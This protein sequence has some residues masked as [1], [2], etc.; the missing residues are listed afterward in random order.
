MKKIFRKDNGEEHNFWMSYTD[1][2]SG[3]LVVFIIA[4]ILY[5][6]ANNKYVEFNDRL[7]SLNITIEQADE[8]LQDYVIKGNMKVINEEFTSVFEIIDSVTILHDQGVIRFYPFQ[9]KEMFE[10]NSDELK[11]N[12]EERLKKVG[13]AFVN[14]AME[15]RKKNAIEIRIEGHADSRRLD[16]PYKDP[17]VNNLLLSSKRAIAVYNCLIERCGLN[18]EEKRFVKENV[19]AV[20]Y[21]S[22]RPVT[23]NNT[24]YA[25]GDE[26]MDKSRRIEFRIISK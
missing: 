23:T 18:D 17:F 16:I 3:F 24:L 5:Q 14:K 4:T 10:N 6:K 13:K 2:L 22:A 8:M 9:D 11:P 1:L 15:L 25:S 7:N 19:I 21:S 20:G 26:D 12:L